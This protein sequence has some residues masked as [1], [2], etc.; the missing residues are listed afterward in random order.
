MSAFELHSSIVDIASVNI[1]QS[2]RE[3]RFLHQ[4]MD[5]ILKEKWCVGGFDKVGILPDFM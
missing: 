1:T 2:C 3:Y 4:F 5:F